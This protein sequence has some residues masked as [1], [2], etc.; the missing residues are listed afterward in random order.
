MLCYVMLCYVIFKWLHI[1]I[2]CH[3]IPGVLVLQAREWE[4]HSIC[5]RT[6]MLPCCSLQ[7]AAELT[8]LVVPPLKEDLRNP[9][10][11]VTSLAG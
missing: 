9:L 6:E 11:F 5:C 10:S 8:V 7:C 2:P 4:A 3:S 1:I